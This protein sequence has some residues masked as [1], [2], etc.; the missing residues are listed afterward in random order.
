M[1]YIDYYTY[2]KKGIDK[3]LKSDKPEDKISALIWTLYS[4]EDYS[5]SNQLVCLYL[6]NTHKTLKNCAIK[7]IGHLAR[8]FGELNPI[9]LDLL[10]ELI[11]KEE[12][13]DLKESIED[14]WI[15]YYRKDISKL[16]KI[17]LSHPNIYM[18][19]WISGISNKYVENN[20]DEGVEILTGLINTN[21]K[22]ITK[23]K[24]YSAIQYIELFKE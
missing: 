15:F 5:L 12:D 13:F 8:I 1:K 24:V 23:E 21:L 22:P 16:E 17:K 6:T 14:I 18:I 11:E 7:C 10:E 3:L 2:D 19:M 9:H 20:P 4:S